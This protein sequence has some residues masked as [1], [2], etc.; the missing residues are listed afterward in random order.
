MT[1]EW[2]FHLQVRMPQGRVSGTGTE[3]GESAEGAPGTFFGHPSLRQP[4]CW[5]DTHLMNLD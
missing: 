3:V 2:V 5:E 4:G 1:S